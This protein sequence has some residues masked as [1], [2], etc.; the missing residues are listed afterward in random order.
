MRTVKRVLSFVVMIISGLMLV[1]SPLGI[2]G[3]WVLRGQLLSDMAGIVAGAESRAETVQQELDRLGRI[4]AQAADEVAALEQEVQSLGADLDQNQPLIDAISDKLGLQLSPLIDRVS[5]I[6]ART[7]E[8]AAEVNSILEAISA[9]P[10]VTSRV[11]DLEP[12]NQLSEDLDALVREFEV[13][14]TTLDQRQSEIVQGA[15]ALI[16]VPAEQIGAVLDDM[17][18]GVSGTSR[19][20]DRLREGLSSLQ[21]VVRRR[22]TWGAVAL[23]LILAWLALSQVGLGLSA[24]RVFRGQDVLPKNVLPCRAESAEDPRAGDQGGPSGADQR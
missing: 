20:I 1:L 24:W 14:R 3:T 16:V 23:T 5:E 7:R 10:F 12:L 8:T 21:A 11:A 17:E 22:L 19:E 13:L 2:T 6:L 18:A 4:L 15:V 9:L